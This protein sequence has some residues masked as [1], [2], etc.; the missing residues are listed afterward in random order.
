MAFVREF[1]TEELAMHRVRSP[2]KNEAEDTVRKANRMQML[3]L[4][5]I[6]IMLIAAG[7]F[8]YRDAAKK[9]ARV[10]KRNQYNDR[11]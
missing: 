3:L 4:V 8:Y 10:K 5:L 6:I 11:V 1:S 7:Y 2:R 9:R